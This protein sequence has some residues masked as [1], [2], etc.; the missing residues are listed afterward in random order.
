[1]SYETAPST[2]MLATHCAVCFRP[3]RDARS[4]NF[5]IGPDCRKKYG[6]DEGDEDAR[7]AA[8]R[9]I[10]AVALARTGGRDL[11]GDWDALTAATA[12]AGLGFRK[13]AD[14]LAKRAATIRIEEAD[15]ALFV[16]A[17][18]SETTL[19]AWGRIGA[20]WDKERKCRVVPATLRAALWSLLQKFFPD[21]CAFGPRGAFRVESGATPVAHA[22]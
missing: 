11:A 10:H 21:A 15:G 20:R 19:P 2:I 5:G 22:A 9:I 6:F 18:F 7:A 12:L 4:V 16:W 13:L 17:P 3:L 1:M 14:I 8:N